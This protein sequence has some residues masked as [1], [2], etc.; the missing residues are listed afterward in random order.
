MPH[1][2][3]VE[4]PPP[5][6]DLLDDAF[7]RMERRARKEE[8]PVPLPWAKAETALGG[9]LWPGLHVLVGN[10][11]SGKSQW[12]LQAGL[13]AAE[14]GVP[15]LYVGLELGRTDLVARLVGL[16]A[17]RKWSR[18][19]LGE[20][21]H[22]VVQM[23]KDH[24]AALK[25]LPFHLEVGGPYGWSYGDLEPLASAFR[26]RYV[27]HLTDD[28]GKTTRPFLLV[29]DYLQVVAGPKG[30]N[31]DLR[32]RIQHAAYAGR[33]VARD[34]DAAVL[35]VSSTAREHYLTLQGQMRDRNGKP[36]D[37]KDKPG[38]GPPARFVGLGKESGEIEYSADT[39]LALASEPWPKD[40][41][42][43]PSQE[44]PQEGT[45]VWLAVAKVRAG[46]PSWVELRFDGG[47]FDIPDEEQ[48]VSFS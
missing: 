17:G 28:A 18:L 8:L 29:L 35:L 4:V 6:G 46:Q 32:H 12:A 1:P 40:D 20:D 5:V 26:K 44:P 36:K 33:A 45:H 38:K 19:W 43:K 13:Y 14:A 23:K 27:K 39:V 7:D 34:M 47:R 24:A 41:D 48:E 15:T 10:T 31:E 30:M 3:A 9:G 22:E 42:G 2:D 11:G 37:S 25:D 16:K 21:Y